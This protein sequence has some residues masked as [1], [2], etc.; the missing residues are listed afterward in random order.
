MGV[1]HLEDAAIG[2]GRGLEIRDLGDDQLQALGFGC[3][4]SQ[5]DLPGTA[6]RIVNHENPLDLRQKGFE[7]LEQQAWVRGQAMQSYRA[8]IPLWNIDNRSSDD[9]QLLF[10]AA[11]RK[12][13]RLNSSHH[14]SSYAV[15]C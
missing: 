5:T 8:E 13:T 14:S 2:P 3:F 9:R 7:T 11:D 15:F 12:S 1:G 10:Q 4:P 6:R